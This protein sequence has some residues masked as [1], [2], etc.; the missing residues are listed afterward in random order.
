MQEFGTYKLILS[1]FDD[2]TVELLYTS[3]NSEDC[4]TQAHILAEQSYRKHSEYSPN[5]GLLPLRAKW[6]VFNLMSYDVEIYYACRR[7]G[8]ERD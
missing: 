8:N 3:K 1:S 4:V 5:M 2:P 7:T 6:V